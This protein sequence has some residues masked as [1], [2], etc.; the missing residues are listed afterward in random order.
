MQDDQPMHQKQSR[1]ERH[2]FLNEATSRVIPNLLTNQK[3]RIT[4][5]LVTMMRGAL[6]LA[7]L[8]LFSNTPVNE[9]QA[10]RYS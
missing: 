1:E 2:P 7:A 10:P 9:L 5:E 6:S 3:I 4:S 8:L